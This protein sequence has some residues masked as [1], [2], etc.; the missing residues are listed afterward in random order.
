MHV[1]EITSHLAQSA[2]LLKRRNTEG[3]R[4]EAQAGVPAQNS[5]PVSDPAAP[6][7][8]SKA[9][10]ELLSAEERKFF[11]NLFPDAA[12]ELQHHTVYASDGAKTAAELGKLIDRKG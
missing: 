5:Q 4:P 1:N 8:P 6:A 9:P 10:A 11:E 12:P 3:A 7:A 2:A